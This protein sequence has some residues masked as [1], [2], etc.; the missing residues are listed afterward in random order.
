LFVKAQ[1]QK[2]QGD[3]LSN[4]GPRTGSARKIQRPLAIGIGIRRQ[5]SRDARGSRNGTPP[6]DFE[7]MSD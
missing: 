7:A 4:C 3:A 1:A 6:V 5:T 2:N